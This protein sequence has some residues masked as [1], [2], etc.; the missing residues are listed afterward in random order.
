MSKVYLSIGTNLGNKEQNLVSAIA[1]IGCCI[2]V[3]RK[4]SNFISTEPVGFETNNQFLNA[5]LLVITD[6]EPLVLLHKLQEIELKLGR[7]QKT[8][9]IYSDRIIDIDILLYDDIKIVLPELKIPHP[10]MLE[11]DF[12]LIPLREIAPDLKIF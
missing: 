2:G 9:D 3:V 8:S 12:V 5:A 6:L 4:I 1:E 11:R 7:T 10:K